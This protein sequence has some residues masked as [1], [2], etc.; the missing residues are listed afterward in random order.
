MS[1][2]RAAVAVLWRDHVD[3]AFP[4]GLR[5]AEPEGVDLVL[6]DAYLAGCVSVWRNNGGRL[7][8]ER[9]RILL[10]CAADLDRVLPGIS[11]AE[12]RRYLLR[13]RRLAALTA[14]P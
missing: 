1:D 4:A 8:A 5:G 3:A 11:D 9:H 6:L 10:A 7:D 13:L 2:R 14:V 12:E